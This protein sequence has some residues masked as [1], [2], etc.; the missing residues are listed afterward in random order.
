MLPISKQ[1]PE[2]ATSLAIPSFAIRHILAH[3]PLEFDK[4]DQRKNDTIIKAVMIALETKNGDDQTTIIILANALKHDYQLKL[5]E[6]IRNSIDKNGTD[7]VIIN[8]FVIGALKLKGIDCTQEEDGSVEM[9]LTSATKTVEDDAR[10]K[11]INET[12]Q[13]LMPKAI[14]DIISC[15]DDQLK[16]CEENESEIIAILQSDDLI[17]KRQIFSTASQRDDIAELNKILRKIESP[18]KSLDLSNIDLSGLN[19]PGIYFSRVNL[20][21][22]NLIA[23]NLNNATFSKSTL[24][25]ANLHKAKL[26]F[27]DFRNETDMTGVDLS[28]ANLSYALMT[29][30]VLV[31][32]NLIGANLTSTWLC[33]TDLTRAKLT[34]ANFYTANLSLARLIDIQM[35][36]NVN[37]NKTKFFRTELNNASLKKLPAKLREHLTHHNPLH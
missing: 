20:N 2:H 12:L 34:G 11:N 26:T 1:S 15:Y 3:Q 32:A 8:A 18:D 22:A 28:E 9:S 29:R 19:L 16:I 4:L 25:D 5:N 31:D 30:A 33:G 37:W 17:A 7:S 23:T 14:C 24:R 21:N 6:L 36:A 13:L 27:A 10:S 35:M